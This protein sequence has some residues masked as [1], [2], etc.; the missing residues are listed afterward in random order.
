MKKHSKQNY[1]D[2]WGIQLHKDLCPGYQ[3]GIV[4]YFSQVD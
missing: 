3:K 2:F 1:F 4:S